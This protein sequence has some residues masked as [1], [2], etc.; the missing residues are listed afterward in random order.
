MPKMT[1]K[2][3]KT[4]EHLEN[5]MAA[6]VN[7]KKRLELAS[8][9]VGIA[10]KNGMSDLLEPAVKDLTAAVSKMNLSLNEMSTLWNTN[11]WK[12]GEQ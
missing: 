7:A 10:Q 8:L 4:R 11:F 9:R 5:A 12:G 6:V 1:V 2:Q 3:E